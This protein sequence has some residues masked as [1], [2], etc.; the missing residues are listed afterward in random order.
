[1]DSIPLGNFETFFKERILE[2]LSGN[3]FLFLEDSLFLRQIRDIDDQRKS[4]LEISKDLATAFHQNNQDERIKPGV[5][6]LVKARIVDDI[7]YIIIKYDH[8]NVITYTQEGNKAFLKEITNTFSKNK[9]ALQKSAVSDINE[10]VAYALVIDKSD[11]KNITKFFKGF[12]GIARKYDN[13]TL[14]EKVKNAY[15]E[16]I[17]HFKKELPKEMLGQTSFDY[18]SYVQTKD[19]FESQ[20]FLPSILG[21]NYKPEMFNIFEKELKKLDILGEEFTFDKSLKKPARKKYYT[22][23]GIKIEFSTEVE[24]KVKITYGDEET[25]ITITTAQLIEDKC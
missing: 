8:E 14:T 25:S 5:M 20:T 3:K 17:K 22:I 18:Y 13:R 4:F 6:I 24:D 23:E 19:S 21:V 12:L 9:S 1:M 10:S 15:I 7:K 2:I 11:P 16:T